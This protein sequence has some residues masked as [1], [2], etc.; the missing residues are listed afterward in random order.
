MPSIGLDRIE[1]FGSTGVAV[2]PYTPATDKSSYSAT[3][4]RHLL[5]STG[6]A[7]PT[8]DET[9]LDLLEVLICSPAADGSC[10]TVD[11]LTFAGGDIQLTGNGN[12]GSYRIHW[13]PPGWLAGTPLDVRVS[14]AGMDVDSF[15]Y[16][17]ASAQPKQIRFTIN[18]HPRIRAHVLHV[19]GVDAAPAA[20]VLIQEF[21]LGSLEI[22]RILA[23]EGYAI[24]EIGEILLD[25]FN[26]TP[27]DAAWL[28]HAAKIDAGEVGAVLLDVYFQDADQTG[29]ILRSVGYSCFE[30]IEAIRAR[31]GDDPQAVFEALMPIG[32]APDPLTCEPPEDGGGRELRVRTRIVDSLSGVLDV[33]FPG[34]GNGPSH[35]D[36][37]LL[38]ALRLSVAEVRSDGSLN[39][40][41]V[42]RPGSGI[43]SIQLRM[44]FYQLL[45]HPAPGQTGKTFRVT[46]S[47]AD[48]DLA[49]DEFR[50]TTPH[51]LPIKFRIDDH[52]VIR[53]RVLRQAGATAAEIVTRLLAEFALQPGEVAR[54]LSEEP[55]SILELGEGLRDG[56]PGGPAIVTQALRD[57]GLSSTT[58]LEILA[59]VF[60]LTGEESISIMRLA[61]Y[62]ATDVWQALEDIFDWNLTKIEIELLKG[63]F[64][65]D[66]VLAASAPRLMIR[67][68]CLIERSGPRIYFHEDEPF[69]PSSIDWVVE[70]SALVWGHGDV[71]CSGCRLDPPHG[72]T[73]DTLVDKAD[74]IQGMTL[75]DVDFW[76]DPPT[77]AYA[78]DLASTEMYVHAVRL[79]DLQVTDIQFWLFYPYNGPGS[80]EIKS[81]LLSLGNVCH[82]PNPGNT[83]PLGEH[84]S[85]WE[86][87]V[88]R[89]DDETGDLLEV[90]MS[91]HGDYHRY[92]AN[93]SGA[94]CVELEDGQ[95]VVARSGLN[96][97][98]Y[99][100]HLGSNP[101]TLFMV[102][103]GLGDI[104]L[105]ANNYTNPPGAVFDSWRQYEFIGLDGA[106]L[107]QP[108]A[109][110]DG[111]WGETR[112]FGLN[113]FDKI[114]VVNNI[115]E[116]C[117]NEIRFVSIPVVAGI[118][119]A[120][121]CAPAAAFFGIGYGACLAT[122]VPAVIVNANRVITLALPI[123]GPL[124]I[125]DQFGEAIGFG[126]PSPASRGEEWKHFV[127]PN[128]D[129]RAI[130]ITDKGDSADVIRRLIVTIPEKVCE[131]KEESHWR[132]L[133][134]KVCRNTAPIDRVELGVDGVY[135]DI[136]SHTTGQPREYYFDWD[137]STA[138]S[139][140]AVL[141]PRYLDSD[142]VVFEYTFEDGD[143]VQTGVIDPVTTLQLDLESVVIEE[144]EMAVLDGMFV[145]SVMPLTAF[146]TASQGMSSS[147]VSRAGTFNVTIDWGDGSVE[148][149][150]TM[151]LFS[152]S[153][154]YVD[155]GTFGIDV[156]V[157]GQTVSAGTVITVA[158]RTPEIGSLTQSS[159]ASTLEAVPVTIDLTASFTDGGALDTH[160]AEW[161][162]DDG[163]STSQV[164]VT[165]PINASY[166]YLS[167]GLYVPS[168]VVMDDDG[169]LARA[170]YE[171]VVVS[172]AG[173]TAGVGAIQAPIADSGDVSTDFTFSVATD[174]MNPPTVNLQVNA[175]SVVISGVQAA[176][177]TFAGNT[178]EV[179][180]LAEIDG[181]AMTTTGEPL[182]VSFRAVDG[183]SAPADDALEIRIWF[184]DANN[185]EQIVYETDP[186]QAL[187]SGDIVVNAAGGTQGAGS[188]LGPDPLAFG[189]GEATFGF[190]LSANSLG[191]PLVDFNFSVGGLLL[192]GVRVPSVT[193]MNGELQ[194]EG[195]VDVNGEETTPDMYPY[196][197]RITALDAP[198]PADD[199]FEVLVWFV[200]AN[201][202]DR[203]V[204]ETAVGQKLLRGEIR[205]PVTPPTP[206]NS[207]P[208]PDRED[209]WPGEN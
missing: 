201:N 54:V 105:F 184:L 175:G 19:Q 150:V 36:R 77:T 49:F 163:T 29:S 82:A 24:A 67:Y 110:F 125:D 193:E 136:T 186:G 102:S 13:G 156:T 91:A 63:G 97:H 28:M 94:H 147:L 162:W 133:R 143:V 183:G 166:T 100:P 4:I 169:D 50:L 139:S 191:D 44:G 21:R 79:K 52:P 158:N 98:A 41:S 190:F 99:F 69:M 25:R 104:G 39:L 187:T 199:T 123:A 126:K 180:G 205:V 84:E 42:F 101:S 5:P 138:T 57:G 73:P 17:P 87:L 35:F 59:A 31:F 43:N 177:V 22:V 3:W 80:V 2:D 174:P 89:F 74:E 37:T 10:A 167:A 137:T 51:A 114:A 179:T 27:E 173:G 149:L 18:D 128:E 7:H 155:D 171:P 62:P 6:L 30:I 188:I 178:V 106:L 86:V 85:D 46:V 93:C 145:T 65:D 64:S 185:V 119:C 95:H 12:N 53:A 92:D 9:L 142:G 134:G 81:D 195:G 159:D 111:L 76:L 144:G 20:D 168:I 151:E 66:E 181:N 202:V 208:G 108:W 83:A 109:G 118:S 198:M 72:L 157:T 116:N 32:C 176:A 48:L 154:V 192:E 203:V 206:S 26:E 135:T 45:W 160:D 56:L 161:N 60:G 61:G 122:C 204:Y 11:T 68:A 15:G 75:G 34:T 121:A 141:S 16:L 55:I 33:T 113:F 131:R 14:V 200:D 127:I 165:S 152:A 196:R 140:K 209:A 117:I 120:V 148:T 207:S 197:V 103:F 47:V 146:Q 182:E 58:T 8:F 132:Q 172:D 153:H 124:I 115:A 90:Y 164:S 88:L 23:A 70:R 112:D 78:G 107:D 170:V 38:E 130:S 71:A 96:G 194:I 129:P 1:E 40:V 189:S